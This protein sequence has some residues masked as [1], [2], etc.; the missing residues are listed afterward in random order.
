MNFSEQPPSKQWSALKYRGQTIAE[1]WFKPEG[2]PFALSFRIPQESFQIPEMDQLLT[3]ENLLKAV[4]I[5]TEEVDSC[6]HEG[7]SPSGMNEPIPE[8]GHPLSPPPQE[9]PHLNLYISLRPPPEPAAREESGEPAIPEAKWQDLQARW[10]AILGLEGSVETL[11]ISMEALRSEMEASSKKTLTPDEKV[12]A[13]NADVAQWN[14]AKS[15]VNYALPKLREYIHRST[16][17]T[18]TPERKRLEEIFKHQ[19]RPYVPL[20]RLE[21]LVALLES[22]L[23]DRQVLSQHGVAVQQECKCI[24]ADV[25]GTLRTLQSNAASIATKKRAETSTRGKIR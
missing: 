14:K 3:M 12:H 8:P 1:V 16:W 10:N 22:L 2:E 7:A 6:R 18:A 5:A 20:S 13:L 4:G 9:V 23:K 17:A 21:E 11:R 25:Q 24:V 15:R 19:V